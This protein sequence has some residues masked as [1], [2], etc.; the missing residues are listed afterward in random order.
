LVTFLKNLFGLL[1][2]YY[3]YTYIS[4]IIGSGTDGI[5][6]AQKW[7]ARQHLY[8]KL[9]R[10][11]DLLGI[12]STVT[13]FHS[14]AS[15]DNIGDFYDVAQGLLV[16]YQTGMTGT[17]YWTLMQ[18]LQDK[19]SQMDALWVQWENAT[20]ASR[21]AIETQIATLETAYS[22]DANA[23]RALENQLVPQRIQAI[24][25]LIPTNNA[26]SVSQVYETN[27]KDINGV[28]LH[29]VAKGI[30][31]FTTAQQAT[32]N[33]IAAQ[34]P[35]S[36]GSSVYVARG[37]QRLYNDQEYDDEQLCGQGNEKGEQSTDEGIEGN[38]VSIYPNPAQDV[39]QIQFT[40]TTRIVSHLI[41]YDLAGRE[42]S[43]HLL[44]IGSQNYQIAT[45]HLSG[46]IY[47][48]KIRN[49]EKQLL[50]SGKLVISR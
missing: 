10:H 26:I 16:A 44:P 40:E 50:S 25:A 8:D 34:C 17:N 41:F 38:R 5:V 49:E 14:A 43:V 30:Y 2:D 4:D 35:L 22:N 32:I 15:S 21:P 13:N 37:L 6:K 45:N 23:W 18:S 9:Q 27:E 24:D 36:G 28:F 12:N 39:L 42:L 46:G 31:T 3:K 47:F 48:Y 33:S 20:P 7:E 19:A 29:T 11:P 1:W